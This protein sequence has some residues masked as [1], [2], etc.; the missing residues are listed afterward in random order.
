MLIRAWFNPIPHRVALIEWGMKMHGPQE[1]LLTVYLL[2]TITVFQTFT[3]WWGLALC[4]L[5]RFHR[6]KQMASNAL[7]FLLGRALVFL[8]TVHVVIDRNV[9]K[10]SD[11]SH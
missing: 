4:I 1:E 2:V 3:F 10:L 7:R 9:T 11:L 5:L 8:N 6:L